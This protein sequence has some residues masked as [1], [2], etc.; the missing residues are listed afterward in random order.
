MD[1]KKLLIS[2]SGG[3]TSAY[4]LWWAMNE[5]KDRDQY[6]IKVV[7]ANTGKEREETLQFVQECAERWSIEVIWVEARHRD[8]DGKPY[9]EKGWSVK[10]RVV[11][12][13]TAA[14]QGEPFEE[15]LSV[16][17]IPSSN[18]PFCSDQLKRKAIESY[19]KSIGWTDFYKAIG[20]RVDE[21][22]RIDESFRKKKILYL[23]INP[24]PTFKRDV[25]L[26]WRR[27]DFD[28]QVPADLGNCD[29]CWKK[30]MPRLVRVAKEEPD[31][32]D[33]WQDMTDT[34]G[35]MN[36]REAKDKHGRLLLPPFNFYRGNKSPKDILKLAELSLDQL[37]LLVEEEKLNSCSESCEVVW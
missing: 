33:W 31:T 20:I 29:G 8:G 32:F 5:W 12:Y 26:W 3:R 30:D 9:S 11:S 18:A 24:H 25:I 1:K 23:L 4:M 7:F 10:H 37:E 17:G 6:D 14:R 36:P 21:V 34:Y 35:E 22:D 2:F 13:L 16:L 19:L 15:M 28:L 27:Q